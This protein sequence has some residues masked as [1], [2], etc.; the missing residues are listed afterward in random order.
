VVGGGGANK[1]SAAIGGV[2]GTFNHYP[3]LRRHDKLFDRIFFDILLFFTHF[4]NLNHD[5]HDTL[6]KF[7]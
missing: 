5:Y 6:K 7:P 4:E 3:V 2:T 1:M